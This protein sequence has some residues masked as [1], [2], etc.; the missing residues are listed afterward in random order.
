MRCTDLYQ[1]YFD[2]FNLSYNLPKI[3][4][5]DITGTI[6]LYIFIGDKSK[7]FISDK[8]KQFIS[9][10]FRE[11]VAALVEIKILTLHET[12][13][14]V[15]VLLFSFHENWRWGVLSIE[16][17]ILTQILIDS[18]LKILRIVPKDRILL[19]KCE[20]FY[21]LTT[22][23]WSLASLLWRLNSYLWRNW[24]QLHVL[25]APNWYV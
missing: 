25:G 5:L 14:N 4:T 16:E 3:R 12:V 24:R 6:Y 7:Q 1:L 19:P 8:S 20:D 13:S 10:F 23:D 21:A 2:F 17:K 11:Q 22:K 9:V 18:R 15:Q